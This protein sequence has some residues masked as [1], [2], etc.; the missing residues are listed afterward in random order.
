MRSPESFGEK[1]TRDLFSFFEILE[2]NDA[3]MPKR[4][5]LNTTPTFSIPLTTGL[6]T[7]KLRTNSS[8]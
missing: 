4:N 7:K 1:E 3:A 8:M 6:E 5:N 2:G